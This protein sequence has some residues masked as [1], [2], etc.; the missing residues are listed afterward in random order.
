A[1]VTV[2]FTQRSGFGPARD[3]E[4][5]LRVPEGLTA[6]PLDPVRADSVAPGETFTARFAVSLTGTPTALVAR[7]VAGAAYARGGRAVPSKRLLSSTG[8]Q[9]PYRTVSFND[10]VLGQAGGEIAIEGSGADLWGTTNEFGA[11][12]LPGA[13]ADG[14]VATVTVTS[15]DATAGWARAGLFV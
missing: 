3:V 13:L 12:Y 11:V 8:V 4:L 5:S 7:T 6:E 15:Q 1:T 10:A 2:S 14:S 9:D